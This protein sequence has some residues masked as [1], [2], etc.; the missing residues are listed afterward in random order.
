M[1]ILQKHLFNK[2]SVIKIIILKIQKNK[3]ILKALIEE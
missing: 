2:Y 1:F 3:Q